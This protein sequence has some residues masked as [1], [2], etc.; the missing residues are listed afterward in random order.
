MLV[1]GDLRRPISK[2]KIR[3][4]LNELLPSY[5]YS[6][7]KYNVEEALKLFGRHG[8]KSKEIF[9]SDIRKTIRERQG[10]SKVE[11]DVFIGK[12]LNPKSRIFILWI[13]WMKVVATYLFLVVPARIAFL[14]WDSLIDFPGL[15]PDLL[16]DFFTVMNVLILANTSFFSSTSKWATDR[17]KILR[18]I[19]VGFI[20]SAVPL[21]WYLLFSTA[22]KIEK[23]YLFL[24]R[25]SY[26][27]GASNEMSCWL[28]ITKLC[29][30]L[31]LISNY[32][33]KS[34]V[35][36]GNDSSDRKLLSLS[37]V[38]FAIVHIGAC[39][40]FYI[41]DRYP[42]YFSLSIFTVTMSF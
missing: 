30:P 20:L 42:V 41:G 36:N 5:P 40:W 27:C 4:F 1:S 28:R 26:W 32:S 12:F 2:S 10:Q 37:G 17:T 34:S 25:F 33:L 13:N 19:D 8:S 22:F 16:A 35:T 11:E 24:S 6:I 7:S 38:V 15:C 29:L 31:T 18:N 39:I 23:K 21:D 3:D 14:P 9:W